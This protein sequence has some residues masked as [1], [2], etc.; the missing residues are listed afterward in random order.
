[1]FVDKRGRVKLIKARRTNYK[2]RARKEVARIIRYIEWKYLLKN[3]DDFNRY[4][5]DE[6][7]SDALTILE[8]NEYNVLVKKET[9]GRIP[10]IITISEKNKLR[11]LEL[12]DTKDITYGELFELALYIYCFKNFTKEEFLVNK[13]NEWNFEIS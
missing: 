9:L 4:I 10:R 13:L 6:V 1:M 3:D 12:T 5:L 7:I 11:I 8:N 2:V